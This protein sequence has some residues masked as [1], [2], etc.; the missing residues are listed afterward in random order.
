MKI[1]RVSIL[2]V[3]TDESTLAAAVGDQIFFF[4]LLSLLNKVAAFLTL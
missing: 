3:S 4:Y 2:A 1:G